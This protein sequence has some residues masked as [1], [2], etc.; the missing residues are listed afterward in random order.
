MRVLLI[1][2]CYPYGNDRNVG[3]EQVFAPPLGLAS[4]ASV[5]RQNGHDVRILDMPAKAI[6]PQGVSAFIRD[7]APHLVGISDNLSFTRGSSIEVARAVKEAS[8]DIPVVFG[9][10]DAT[11]SYESILAGSPEVD[12]VLRYEGEYTMLELARQLEAERSVSSCAGLAYRAN[13]A[14]IELNE[15]APKISNLDALPLPACDLLPM[16]SYRGTAGFIVTSRGCPFRCAYCSTSTFN[17]R[18]Y[19]AMSPRRVIEEVEHLIREYG[20]RDISFGDDTYT[21]KRERVVAICEEIN[22]RKLDIRWTANTRVDLVDYDLLRLM[23]RAG[24]NTLLFGIESSSQEVLDRIQKGF[25]IGEARQAIQWCRNLGIR[26]TECF[27]IGLPGETSESAGRIV[28]FISENPADV[29]SLG[30]LALYPG[31]SLYEESNRFG[32]KILGYE[33]A[34]LEQRLPRFATAW[35][36]KE[37]ILKSYVELV[38]V[39]SERSLYKVRD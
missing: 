9:G 26:V 14:T 25:R 32:I 21:L 16:S 15:E 7:F 37:T 1:N 34:K 24:C 3:P 4:I 29:L 5:L 33:P 36:S 20:V 28:D 19:R 17:G 18:K 35:M 12:F 23:R 39:L 27:I 8:K 30:I 10:N 38:I 31:S 22:R 6:R 13:E 2:P 11:F